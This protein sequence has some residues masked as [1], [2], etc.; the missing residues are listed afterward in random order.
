MHPKDAADDRE[1]VGELR[2]RE[3]LFVHTLLTSALNPQPEEPHYKHFQKLVASRRKSKLTPLTDAEERRWFSFE[4]FLEIMGLATL[5]QEE[6]GGL[7]ALHAHINHSCDPNI[8]V[9][10]RRKCRADDR[11]ATCQSLLLFQVPISCLA[12]RRH[13]KAFAARSS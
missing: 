13:H 2:R 5:N 9:K 12:I 4:S 6:S 1:L 10:Q 8:M 7:Y 3:W 11:V